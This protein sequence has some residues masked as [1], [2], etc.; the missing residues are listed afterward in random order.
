MR[1]SHLPRLFFLLSKRDLLIVNIRI[2]WAVGQNLYKILTK[3]TANS[4][5]YLAKNW[6]RIC[7]ICTSSIITFTFNFQSGWK[8]FVLPFTCRF[9]ALLKISMM[10]TFDHFNSEEKKWQIR[11]L[12]FTSLLFERLFLGLSVYFSSEALCVP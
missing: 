2:T 1:I 12:K 11:E 10:A 7:R 6:H 8:L 5:I 4:F 9:R 3:H